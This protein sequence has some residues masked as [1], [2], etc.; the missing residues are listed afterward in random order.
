M[1]SDSCLSLKR[2]FLLLLHY[3][4]GYLYIYPY[5]ASYIT[6]KIDPNATEYPV[7]IQIILYLY[8]FAVAVILAYPL[9]CKAYHNFIKKPVQILKDTLIRFG[10]LYLSMIICNLILMFLLP[11]GATSNNQQEILDSLMMTPVLTT[12]VTIA[13]APVVEE[14]IFRGCLYAKLREFFNYRTCLLISSLAFGFLHVY[15]SLIS[16]DFLDCAYILTYSVMGVHFGILYE[17]HDSL[18]PCIILHFMNNA[19]AT[20]LMMI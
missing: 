5:L 17:K 19:L 16:G 2:V 18:M 1:K 8:V 6:L 14:V 7:F 10:W 12:L 3:F 13:F 20:L 4:A 15:Q 11:D 9:L